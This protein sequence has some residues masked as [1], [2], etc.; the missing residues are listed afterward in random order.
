M[1][2]REDEGDQREEGLEEHGWGCGSIEGVRRVQCEQSE[3]RATRRGEG[4]RSRAKVQAALVCFASDDT[5]NE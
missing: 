1:G 4:A 3:A 5:R 2:D